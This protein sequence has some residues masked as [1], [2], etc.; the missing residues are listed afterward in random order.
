[1]FWAA[2]KGFQMV[3]DPAHAFGQFRNPA[4]IATGGF[5]IAARNEFKRIFG[6]TSNGGQ[7]LIDFV[8]NAS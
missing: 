2:G 8:C 3:G 1:M 6:V 7:W 4:Q 5:V